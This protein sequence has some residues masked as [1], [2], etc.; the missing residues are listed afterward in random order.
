MLVGC[1]RQ[2]TRITDG[3]ARSER[4]IPPRAYATFARA[5]LDE[6]TGNAAGALTGYLEVTRLDSAAFEAWVR[7]G[8]IHCKQGDAKESLR[9]FE[10]AERL[11]A[12]SATLFVAKASCALAVHDTRSAVAFAL[13]AMQ[14]APTSQDASRLLVRALDADGR[15]AEALRYCWAHVA[16]YPNDSAGW[17]KLSELAPAELSQ[18]LQRRAAEHSAVLPNA[19]TLSGAARTRA[20]LDLQHG[21]AN[22]DA[23]LTQ[24]AA[25]ALRLGTAALSQVAMRFGAL[26]FAFSEGA[27]AVSIQPDD[28]RYWL[29]QLVLADWLQDDDAFE[30]LLKHPP[31]SFQPLTEVDRNALLALI[32]RRAYGA[33]EPTARNQN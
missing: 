30:S 26:D 32:A 28:A 24:R 9:A 23:R 3:T 12:S 19:A 15:R 33:A 14:F 7:I 1:A 4:E 16:T 6:A 8:S 31:T 2:V 18:Q 21:L 20:E 10:R 5:R 13:N 17:Q 25:R 27:L 11:N 29:R 22:H